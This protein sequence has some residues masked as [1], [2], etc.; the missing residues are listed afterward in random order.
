[1]CGVVLV[2]VSMARFVVMVM[3]MVRLGLPRDFIGIAGLGLRVTG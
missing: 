3:V 1:M 2:L